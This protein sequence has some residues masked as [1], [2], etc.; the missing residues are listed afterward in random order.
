M[1]FF[2][3]GPLNRRK[4]LSCKCLRR[5][6]EL[7]NPFC[8]IS[9]VIVPNDLCQRCARLRAER[10]GR[11]SRKLSPRRGDESGGWADRA[12]GAAFGQAS[13]SP[14]GGMTK[15]ENRMSSTICRTCS[16]SCCSNCSSGSW[17]SG[18]WSGWSSDIGR[19]SLRVIPAGSGHRA[20]PRPAVGF[21]TGSTREETVRFGGTVPAGGRRDQIG[22]FREAQSERWR[23]ECAP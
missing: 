7:F 15:L 17:G 21:P 10:D 1:L 2:D 20:G 13:G 18:P 12:T 6:G 4:S 23:R 3:E 5:S 14:S 22:A 16:T 9:P 8:W 11:R 19:K